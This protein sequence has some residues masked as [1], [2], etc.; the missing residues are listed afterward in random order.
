ML[1]LHLSFSLSLGRVKIQ[2]RHSEN[3]QCKSDIFANPLTLWGEQW[4]Q[5]IEYCRNKGVL[6]Q[7]K[8]AGDESKRLREAIRRTE[9]KAESARQAA[10]LSGS[11]AFHLSDTSGKLD[12]T[13]CECSHPSHWGVSYPPW[14]GVSL[15]ATC[16]GSRDR[17][18]HS[19]K[20]HVNT[21]V[22]AMVRC[23]EFSF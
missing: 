1:P 4:S 9:A 21:V 8:R 15:C 5:N 14:W 22:I 12:S 7:V 11:D 18:L 3:L 10:K 16:K 6:P 20:P 13:Q 17:F 2:P 23:T 19:I